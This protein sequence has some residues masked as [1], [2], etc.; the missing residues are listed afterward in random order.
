MDLAKGHVA[1]LEYA[2]NHTGREV[3]NLGTG[4]GYSVLDVVRTFEK[5]VGKPIAFEITSRRSGDVCRSVAD[6]AKACHIL[7]WSPELNLD[8]MCKDA[9]RWHLRNPRGYV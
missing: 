9:W 5:S 4:V 2:V 6:P 7:D 3:F 1:A 8:E